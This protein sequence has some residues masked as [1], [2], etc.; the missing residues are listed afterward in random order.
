M[1]ATALRS[2]RAQN[3]LRCDTLAHNT[4][5][6]LTRLPS[7]HPRH[8]QLQR[9][10]AA[11]RDQARACRAM[12]PPLPPLRLAPT[13]H[14]MSPPRLAIP[15]AS[16]PPLHLSPN[17]WADARQ[18][19]SLPATPRRAR[20]A[21]APRMA[22]KRSLPVMSGPAA[23]L[24]RPRTVVVPSDLSLA[25]YAAS[26]LP[27]LA[28]V[29]R[30]LLAL[31]RRPPRRELRSPSYSSISS[32]RDELDS[33]APSRPASPC[34][35]KLPSL[36]VESLTSVEDDDIIECFGRPMLPHAARPPRPPNQ[37]L[38]L[39]SLARL[40]LTLAQRPPQLHAPNRS[41]RR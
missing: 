34:G 3:R 31:L 26:E 19:V 6:R 4:A 15:P 33:P 9:D 14:A 29:A 17:P 5:P 20:N 10:R 28:F 2:R 40:L 38:L 21:G 22:R 39:Q 30:T 41:F 8:P 7:P 1:H 11:T 35:F 32:G 37:S 27:D 25:E 36:S 18:T 16:L 24:L 13:A 12:P 23:A